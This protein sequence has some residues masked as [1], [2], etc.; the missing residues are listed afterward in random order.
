MKPSI[1]IEIHVMS[2]CIHEKAAFSVKRY[3]QVGTSNF[4]CIADFGTSWGTILFGIVAIATPAICLYL[5]CSKGQ[6]SREGCGG[7]IRGALECCC[8]FFGR[9]CEFFG[10]ACSSCVSGARSAGREFVTRIFSANQGECI[11]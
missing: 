8:E 4:F 11:L 1:N 7:M 2:H 6:R 3:L 5:V 9:C 10:Q